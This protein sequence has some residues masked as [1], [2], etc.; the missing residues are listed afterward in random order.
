MHLLFGE[1]TGQ[2]FGAIHLRIERIIR[3]LVKKII[4]A[5]PAFYSSY[6]KGDPLPYGVTS[7]RITCIAISNDIS[8][9][10][11]CSLTS[12]GNAHEQHER[13][14]YLV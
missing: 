7:P 10:R 1:F 9:I 6:N 13:N 5:T 2:L 8:S 14:R 12:N 11:F 3:P 4:K